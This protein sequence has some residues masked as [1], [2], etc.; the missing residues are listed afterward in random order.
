MGEGTIDQW[1]DWMDGRKDVQVDDRWVNGWMDARVNTWMDGWILNYA[2]N[3]S[4]IT[5]SN[6]SWWCCRRWGGV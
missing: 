5:F 6:R 4:E 2:A 3:L 1:T